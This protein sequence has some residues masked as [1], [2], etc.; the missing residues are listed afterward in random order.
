[1]LCL[2]ADDCILYQKIKSPQCSISLYKDLHLLSHWALI[3]QMNFNISKC[4]VLRCSR[5]LM[6]IPYNYWLNDCVLDI[7]E[8]QPYLGIILHK[9]LSWSSHIPKISAKTSQTFNFL[10][11]NLSKCSPPIK[12]SA[13]L[14]LVC[15]IME[16]VAAVW[17]PHQ[18]NNI[19]PLEKSNVELPIG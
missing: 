13:Y 2:I 15:S 19:K 10:Q 16:Y 17:D 9:S 1:M 3:W 7:R 5:S 11:R 4:V 12:A 14:T 18:L 6:P 8:E